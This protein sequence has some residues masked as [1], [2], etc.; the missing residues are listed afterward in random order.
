MAIASRTMQR[1]KLHCAYRM[2]HF[3]PLPQCLSPVSFLHFLTNENLMTFMEF[4]RKHIHTSGFGLHCVVVVNVNI[5]SKQMN[6][7]APSIVMLLENKTYVQQERV[8]E[9][10]GSECVMVNIFNR[11]G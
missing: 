10:I 4:Y 6:H 8:R 9:C 3:Y 7:L 2:V 11:H 1:R 5:Y